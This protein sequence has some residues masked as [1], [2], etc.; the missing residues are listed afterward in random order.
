MRKLKPLAVDEAG[1][2]QQLKSALLEGILEAE[3][4]QRRFVYVDECY[5]TQ[6]SVL[7][8]AYAP[9]HTNL[10][11]DKDKVDLPPVRAIAGVSPQRGVEH[12]ALHGT[13]IT[14]QHIMDFLHD[15]QRLNGRQKLAVY[16]DNVNIHKA[17]N[18][19]D[20]CRQLDIRLLWNIP[21]YPDT[22]PIEAC[23]S[24]V[25]GYFRRR[26]LEALV[27]DAPFDSARTVREAFARVRPEYVQHCERRS[28]NL[29]MQTNFIYE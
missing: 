16:W 8:Q 27:A 7:L 9:R 25:K 18:V 4:E 20:L 24:V 11:V 15:L 23:F 10:A 17:G 22:N 13:A 1:R 29:L 12:L 28:T 6:Q 5:F 19:T 3:R 21:Y 26:R 14:H 2:Y